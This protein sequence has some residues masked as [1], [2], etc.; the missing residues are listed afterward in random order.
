MAN[1]AKCGVDAWFLDG[2]APAKNPQLWSQTIFET[3]ASLSNKDATFA[4]FTSASQVRK[5][6]ANAGFTVQKVA[7]FGRK[8][9][10]L[11]GHYNDPKKSLNLAPLTG[12]SINHRL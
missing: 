1:Y 12:T 9:E 3:V 4:T 8:R 6:L 11:T 7:G 10:S 2:F 5:G